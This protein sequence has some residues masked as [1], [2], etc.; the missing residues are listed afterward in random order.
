M[1]LHS[2][3]LTSAVIAILWTCNQP[4]QGNTN[5]APAEFADPKYMQVGKK[6]LDGLADGDIDNFLKDYA[7]NAVFLWNSGDS[8]AGKPAIYDYWKDRRTNVIDKI[9]YENDIWLALKVN[10]PQKGPDRVGVWL[11]GWFHATITYKSGKSVTQW[12]HTDYHFDNADKIDRA[13][14]YLDRAPINAAITGK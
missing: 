10:K 6:A 4:E 11:L 5:L 8:V 14:M 3:L 7:D 1:K 9:A 2:I 12:I 13:I